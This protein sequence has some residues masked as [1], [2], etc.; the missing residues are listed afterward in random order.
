MYK[1]PLTHSLHC[2]EFV[3]LTL[4][5]LLE[6]QKIN[7]TIKSIELFVISCFQPKL[8]FNLHFVK[9]HYTPNK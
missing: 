4:I 7:M 8:I 2:S 6:L 5:K 9:N 1:E 3:E